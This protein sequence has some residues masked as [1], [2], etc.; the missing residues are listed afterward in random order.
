M[1]DASAVEVPVVAP[2][3]VEPLEVPLDDTLTLFFVG[4]PLVPATSFSAA[5]TS[6]LNVPVIPVAVKRDE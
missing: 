3:V 4:G 1:L 2:V 6:G 5:M